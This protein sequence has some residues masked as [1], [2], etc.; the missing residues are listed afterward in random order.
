MP[1]SHAAETGYDG[2]SLQMDEVETFHEVYCSINALTDARCSRF[3]SVCQ[4]SFS[5]K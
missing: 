4:R 1:F 5:T 3:W 2:A